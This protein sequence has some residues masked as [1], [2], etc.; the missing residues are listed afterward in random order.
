MKKTTSIIASALLVMLLISS[1]AVNV[2]ASTS[3]DTFSLS[4]STGSYS[5]ILPA[6]NKSNY[7]DMMILISTGNNTRYCVR[8]VACNTSGEDHPITSMINCTYYNSRIIDHY[9]VLKGTMYGVPNQVRYT[10]PYATFGILSP[11]NPGTITGRWSSDT[12]QPH[13]YETPIY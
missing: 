7:S 12:S 9:T 1:I 8:T 4:V 10:Y 2:F 5:H 6:K 13:P 11:G 3:H